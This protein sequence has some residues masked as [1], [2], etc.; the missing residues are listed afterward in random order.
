MP[1]MNP[2]I[3]GSEELYISNDKELSEMAI[4]ENKSYIKQI[5]IRYLILQSKPN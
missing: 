2:I 3:G 4:L 5:Y 1:I